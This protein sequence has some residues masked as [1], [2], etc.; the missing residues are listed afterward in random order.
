MVLL[1][2]DLINNRVVKAVKGKRTIAES[3]EFS[4]PIVE[5]E[6]GKES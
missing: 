3:K 2:K 6:D 5:N 1:L 4:K